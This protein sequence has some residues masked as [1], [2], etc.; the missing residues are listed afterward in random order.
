MSVSQSA[1]AVT[2]LCELSRAA[3]CDK[4]PDLR[5]TGDE[6]CGA[7]TE[8]KGVAADISRTA[9]ASA[10]AAGRAAA[11]AA[12]S[13][14]APAVAA[15]MVAV[16]AVAYADVSDVQKNSAGVGIATNWLVVWIAE[17]PVMV[18]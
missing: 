16:S 8:T 17:I 14:A 3:S 4:N 11:S 7:W 12:A 6:L 2:C 18:R 15:G 9:A 1:G 13:P 5:L 10:V